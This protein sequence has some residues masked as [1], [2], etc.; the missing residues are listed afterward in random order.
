MAVEAPKHELS[1]LGVEVDDER[2]TWRVAKPFQP[3]APH[4][5]RSSTSSRRGR[6][7]A[8]APWRARREARMSKGF[9]DDILESVTER[10][11]FNYFMSFARVSGGYDD[12]DVLGRYR[13]DDV[14]T[15]QGEEAA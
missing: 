6:K 12:D 9:D 7:A 5:L 3:G 10:E 8:A 4:A 13:D 1:V 14:A 11:A 15:W 2:L